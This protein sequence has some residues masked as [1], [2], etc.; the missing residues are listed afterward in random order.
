MSGNLCFNSPSIPCF[1]VKDEEGQPLHAPFK[2]TETTPFLNDFK[3]WA[4]FADGDMIC[5]TDIKELLDL[6]DNSKALQVVKHNYKTK[7]Y[8]KYLGILIKTT[9]E[10]IGLVSFYGIVHILNIKF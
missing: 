6:K 5:Q 7:A 8:Q 9:P 1:S 4:I 3:G 10:K 2:T